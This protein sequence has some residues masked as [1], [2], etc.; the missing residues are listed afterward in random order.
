[1]DAPRLIQS[2]RAAGLD[3]NVA[4]DLEQPFFSTKGRLVKVAGEEV[5]LF[6]YSSGAS[7]AAEAARVSRD[8]STVGETKPHWM[9]APHFYRKDKLIVL[10]LGDDARMIKA[11]D[12]VLGRQFAGQ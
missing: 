3:V 7:A 6:Q 8:G 2:L 12:A 4:G 5:Q 9:A 11:L 1:M 10:Y